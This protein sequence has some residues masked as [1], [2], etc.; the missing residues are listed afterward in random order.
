MHT[1]FLTMPHFNLPKEDIRQKPNKLN[2]FDPK[3]SPPG[4]GREGMG[5]ERAQET[6]V[7][8]FR[9]SCQPEVLLL[10]QNIL[11]Y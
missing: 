3:E 11:H 5:L 7:A 6:N 9:S 2:G 1:E 4:T 10:E 8:R